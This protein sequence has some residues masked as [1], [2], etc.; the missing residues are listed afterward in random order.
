[1][2]LHHMSVLNQKT[3]KKSVKFDGVGLH[4]GKKVSMTVHPSEPNTGIIFKR[5]DL[6]K[7]NLVIP[8]VFNVSNAVLCTT[9]SNEYGVSV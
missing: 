5:I 4:T 3:L 2:Y 9:I 6:N 1:M 7:N 8:S